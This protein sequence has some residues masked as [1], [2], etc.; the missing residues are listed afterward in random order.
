[1]FPSVVQ[2]FSRML[3]RPTPLQRP[4]KSLKLWPHALRVAAPWDARRAG[5]R[6]SRARTT[7]L[8]TAEQDFSSGLRGPQDG[9][10]FEGG[11]DAGGLP[12]AF[13]PHCTTAV[14]KTT[15]ALASIAARNSA[16]PGLVDY[17]N[18]RLGL[19]CQ[20]ARLP[21][22]IFVTRPAKTSK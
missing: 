3:L 19:W 9:Q 18:L 2:E 10:P 17:Y 7:L 13:A 16:L 11:P 6:H 8:L 22:N 21:N 4:T 1:M 14:H 12:D 20:R 5:L 15:Q